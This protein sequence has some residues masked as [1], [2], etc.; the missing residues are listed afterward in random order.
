VQQLAPLLAARQ[1][2]AA[3]AAAGFHRSSAARVEAALAPQE[4]PVEEAAQSAPQR[5]FHKQLSGGIWY[6][7]AAL[8]TIN[9]PISISRISVSQ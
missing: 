5:I 7:C 1:A 9:V 3:A 4:C 8:P 6:K 2:P